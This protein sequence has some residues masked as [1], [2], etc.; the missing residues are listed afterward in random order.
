MPGDVLF[1]MTHGWPGLMVAYGSVQAPMCAA[2]AR[3]RATLGR[4]LASPALA[5]GVTA[6][7]GAG[8]A[9]AQPLLHLL[10]GTS[11]TLGVA[12]AA[13]CSVLTGYAAGRAFASS[14]PRRMV[15]HVRGAV[16]REEAGVDSSSRQ[17]IGMDWTN[18]PSHVGGWLT[19]AGARVPAADETKHFKIIGATGAGKSTAIAE[20]LGAA[21]ARGDRAVIAD[22]DAGYARRFFSEQRG[23]AVLSPFE[24]GGRRWDLFGEIGEP[25]DIEQLALALIPDHQGADRSWRGYARTLFAAVAGQARAA[26]VTDV[27]QLFDLLVVADAAEL[28]VLVGGTPAQPFFDEHNA[29][30]LDSIRSVASSAVGA[31]QYVAR[32]KAPSLS[33][34]QWVRS[35]PGVLFIP[36]R[37]GQ[38]AALRSSISAWMRLAI[39]ESMNGVEGG[40]PLWFVIDELDALGPIDGL[41]DALA[42]LRKFGGRCVLGFQSIAQVSTTYGTGE[43]QTIV[44]NCGNSLILRCSASEHGG[45]ARFASRLIGDREI[46]RLTRSRSRRPGEFFHSVSEAE[47]WQVEPAVMDAQIER[48]ADLSGFLKLAS[49]P[50]WQTVRLRPMRHLLGSAASSCA[51][52]NSA[53]RAAAPSL[54]AAAS[55]DEGW[56]RG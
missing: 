7:L 27:G 30:M 8:M 25:Y 44:E 36:Y 2:L 53:G 16:V 48:L 15:T 45:T 55:L 10:G 50:D 54:S 52:A 26:G 21:L 23:D 1:E 56:D 9:A 12:G 3:G 33:V 20:L 4:W 37:A 5:A 49:V 47:H 24:P 46:M 32:Q 42:R 18:G 43:A 14:T 6:G 19:L 29:R 28:K 13:G 41:K 51:G 22:P 39:F 11:A 31:L 34:R 17:R 38:V 40:R 35:G